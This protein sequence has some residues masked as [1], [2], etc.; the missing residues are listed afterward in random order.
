MKEIRAMITQRKEEVVMIG[1]LLSVM[2]KTSEGSGTKPPPQESTP[3]TSRGEASSG[4]MM[5]PYNNNV[6][7]M[8]REYLCYMCKD[9][10][11]FMTDCLHFIEF[12]KWGWLVPEGNGSNHM[13]LWDGVQMLK[14]EGLPRYK[15]IECIVEKMGWNKAS[16]Y[17]ANLKEEE[18][19]T[20]DLIDQMSSVFS[21][22]LK[23]IHDR[24]NQWESRVEQQEQERG[25]EMSF[26]HIRK[27]E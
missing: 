7:S 5:Q 11:H 1:Q 8:P 10:G 4:T 13:K 6:Q 14:D 12:M 22:R 27:N 19:D 16:T 15:Q 17:L 9:K 26:S 20:D 25:K 24:L 3:S 23:E 21:S 18:E 2:G